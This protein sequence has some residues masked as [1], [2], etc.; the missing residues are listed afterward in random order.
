MMKVSTNPYSIAIVTGASKGIGKAIALELASEDYLL[1]CIAKSDKDGLM[2]TVDL[3]K[4]KGF[5]AYPFLCDLSNHHN[6]DLLYQDLHQFNLPISLLINNA[7]ISMVKLFTETSIDDWN[8]VINTN[9][10]S[11]YSM[12]YFAA[13]EMIANQKG[14]IINISSIWGEEGAS[15]EVAYSASKGGLNAF[16]KALAK[17]LGPS[18][19]QVNA[20]A[21]GVI[22]TSMNHFLNDEEANMLKDSISLSRFGKTNEV[23]IFVKSLIQGAPY[24][25]GQVITYDGGMV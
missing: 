8:Q 3:I 2:E 15:M 17:E 5:K 4:S 6:V 16:T 11:V 23:A 14:H 18:Q 25:T 7:G 12:C 24:L 21:C 13:K 19:I 20:V 9:L 10:T 1:V 22:D